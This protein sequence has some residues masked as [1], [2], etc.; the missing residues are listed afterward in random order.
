LS[1]KDDNPRAVPIGPQHPARSPTR[2]GELSP[3]V[4]TRSAK[5][6]KAEKYAADGVW[7]ALISTRV[8]SPPIGG[9]EVRAGVRPRHHR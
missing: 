6:S 2:H 9:G 4:F 3:F 1:P 7:P 8:S 5:R